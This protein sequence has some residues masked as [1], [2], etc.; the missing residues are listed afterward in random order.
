MT[1]D[2][3]VGVSYGLSYMGTQ[4]QPAQRL[5]CI[6]IALIPG[7]SLAEAAIEVFSVKA[8]RPQLLELD[9]EKTP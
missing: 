7:M 8:E 3:F 9:G 2:W 1:S 6:N 5:I 4:R